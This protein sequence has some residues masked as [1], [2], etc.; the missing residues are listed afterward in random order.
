MN[1]VQ[2]DLILT[3]DNGKRYILVNTLSKDF[4]QY[5][6]L[7][8]IDDFGDI[9]FG[10]LE[11]DKITVVKDANLLVELIKSFNEMNQNNQ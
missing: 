7:T 5:A 9:I 8:N 4:I 11:G 6:C 10:K 3:L 1:T 2:N